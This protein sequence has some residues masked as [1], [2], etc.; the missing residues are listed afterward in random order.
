ML[1]LTLS[2]HGMM[3]VELNQYTQSIESIAP[4]ISTSCKL[5][6]PIKKRKLTN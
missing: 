1:L 4:N 3:I 2:S 6:L 5:Y